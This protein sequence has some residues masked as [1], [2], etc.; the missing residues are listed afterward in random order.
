MFGSRGFAQMFFGEGDGVVAAVVAGVGGT[1]IDRRWLDRLER[2][3]QREVEQSQVTAVH[4]RRSRL[5]RDAEE[6]D[7]YILAL[8]GLT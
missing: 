1:P 3:W 7:A 6:E 5:D 4:R 2:R 8:L